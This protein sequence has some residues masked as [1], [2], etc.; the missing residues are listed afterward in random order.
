MSPARY[1]ATFRRTRFIS[2]AVIFVVFPHSARAWGRNG[3]KL[4]V[5]KAIDTLPA[6]IRAFFESN[7]A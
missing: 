6:D 4:V 3:N 2:V 7:R 5:N 1:R